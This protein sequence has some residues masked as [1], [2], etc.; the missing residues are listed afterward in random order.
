MN[1]PRDQTNRQ[2]GPFGIVLLLA[3]F[4]IVALQGLMFLSM[5]DKT[6]GIHSLFG[7]RKSSAPAVHPV[8]VALL[9]SENSAQ[10]SKENSDFFYDLPKQWE[11]S[12]QEVGIPYRLI[13]DKD[14]GAKLDGW[15]SV[16]V[17]PS[18]ICLSDAERNNIRSFL[19]EGNGVIA[20]GGI[21]ARDAKCTW[22]GWSYLTE[23]TGL[24]S[25]NATN[26]TGPSFASFR[27]QQFFSEEIP[28]GYGL[29]IP[30]QELV[31][32]STAS[33]DAV[34]TD[35]HL[36]PIGTDSVT[37]ATV[38]L[39]GVRR[40]G[41]FVWYGF[42]ET[43]PDE[44]KTERQILDKYMI[45]AVRWTGRQPLAF[46]TTWPQ[47]KQAAVMVAE[48]VQGDCRSG[49]PSATLLS[50]EHVPATFFCQSSMAPVGA[51]TIGYL[52]SA[53]EL[54]SAGDT[55]EPLAKQDVA[56]QGQRLANSR[57]QLEKA[58]LGPVFGF[59]PPQN[60]WDDATVVAL[61]NASYSYY[62]DQYGAGRG[63]P[64]FID[65]S[66]RRW[67]LEQP[68]QI[69]RIRST[70]PGDFEVIAGY[71]GPTPYG[72][73]LANLFLQSFRRNLYL[74]VLH[75]LVMRSD[76]LAAPENLHVLQQVVETM[77]AEPV[78]FASGEALTRWWTKR[79]SVRVETRMVNL[80]R[81][82]LAVT[83]R[84]ADSLENATV[85]L[86]LPY[87][88]HNIRV[89]SSILGRALPTTRLLVEEDVLRLDFSKLDAQSGS[90]LIIALDEA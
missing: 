24:K 4:V 87:R 67:L 47:T 85:Y 77:K 42:K 55:D 72:D 62:L 43:L 49:I 45:S 89:I 61:K 84:G 73:D 26:L 75:T 18:A 82:R 60:Q 68:K 50:K 14:L 17:L 16:L 20:S 10:L 13:S 39:H 69:A 76:L 1:A 44:R 74:G 15:A 28:G 2:N 3:A 41:R 54:G 78:W 12:L 38:A 9:R 7:S 46:L 57:V 34:W 19:E 80:R 65:L 27:G 11:N 90:V 31:T 32:G 64:E 81:I 86:H 70:A 6:I 51:K 52:Q 83:N 56:R 8:R 40:K 71:Q 25:P 79:E 66:T 48:E 22:R 23:L 58:S 63:V 36:S 37:D 53:G 30:K 88:P 33:P 29:E 5:V 35:W 21:G 59:D